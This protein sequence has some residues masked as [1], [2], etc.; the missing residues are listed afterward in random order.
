[1][2]EVAGRAGGRMI[3]LS[4]ILVV[5]TF[6]LI[7]MGGQVTTTDS[8]DS[9]PSWPASFFVPKD[10]AQR[11]ELGHRWLAG[12]VGLV[13]VGL[14]AWVLARE[15]SPVTRKLAVA[16]AIFGQLVLGLASW[17]TTHTASGY[18]NPTDASSLIPTL[19]VVLGAGILALSVMIAMRAR[20]RLSPPA[21]LSSS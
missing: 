21:A 3:R 15:R 4:T 18:L 17:T 20:F 10:T 11:W 12:A 8:G 7:F 2:D 13:T 9:V 6:L 14:A 1:S 19:H 16:A 5:L